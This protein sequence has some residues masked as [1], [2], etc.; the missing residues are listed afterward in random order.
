MIFLKLLI[1]VLAVL[2]LCFITACIYLHR[3][4]Q[5][6]KLQNE[7][8][9]GTIP[10]TLPDGFYRGSVNLKTSWQ[11]KRFDR[12]TN[13]GINV[14]ADKEA[15]PFKTYL[16]PG[17]VD[18]QLQVIKI[19]YNV[20][21]NPWYLRP[22]LDEIVQTKPGHFLGKLQ[23]RLLPGITVALGYFRLAK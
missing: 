9:S 10:A 4:A 17:N 14:L 1:L 18:P 20:P 16:G 6:S 15:F 11:G 19:D 13:S 5:T 7:F 22:I 23:L 21:Q 3:R 2:V 8:L 12:A